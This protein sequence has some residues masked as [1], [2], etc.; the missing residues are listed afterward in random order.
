MSYHC[1]YNL[2]LEYRK[3]M[4][5]I[6]AAVRACELNSFSAETWASLQAKRIVQTIAM[7]H[8]H[9]ADCSTLDLIRPEQ[10][11]ASALQPDVCFHFELNENAMKLAC[12]RAGQDSSSVT[13]PTSPTVLSVQ[14]QQTNGNF[15]SSYFFF[16]D[17]IGLLATVNIAITNLPP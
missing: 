1:L 10:N 8:A 14:D 5:T 15:A 12:H 16:S 13:N 17:I 9:F 4:F 11:I 3:T 2:A 7:T 6:R